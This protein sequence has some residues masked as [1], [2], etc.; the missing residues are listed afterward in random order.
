M[1]I[2]RVSPKRESHQNHFLLKAVLKVGYK[3]APVSCTYSH[4]NI[5]SVARTKYRHIESFFRTLQVNDV[6][7]KGGSGSHSHIL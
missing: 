6:L 4:L 1:C 5:V 7:V 3:I 2:Y